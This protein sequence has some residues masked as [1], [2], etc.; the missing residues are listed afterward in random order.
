[1]NG[2]FL[3]HEGCSFFLNLQHPDMRNE[4][5]TKLYVGNMSYRTTEEELRTVFSQAGTVTEVVIIKD[6]ESGRPK[7]FGF[8]TMASAE[9]A[10]A[11]IAKFNGTEVGGRELKVNTARPL[12]ER[13]GSRGGGGNR[14]GYNSN[15]GGNRGG[16]GGN[17]GGYNS[18]RGGG[19]GN[20][21]GGNRGGG[22]NRRSF[23][24]E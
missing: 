13:G 8:V 7:G 2:C 11:A 16:G 19:S 9:D 15:R 22:G 6:K 14:G 5:E 21:S 24:E 17:R 18:N 23:D 1:M 3:H 10:E 12:E 20:R 4:V